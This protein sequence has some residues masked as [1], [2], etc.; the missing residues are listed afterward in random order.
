MTFI[1]LVYTR[2]KIF[3]LDEELQLLKGVINKA[4][5]DSS[6]TFAGFYFRGWTDNLFL[7]FQ[8]RFSSF[9]G[10]FRFGFV[11]FFVF[12]RRGWGR[13]GVVQCPGLENVYKAILAP[14][15][16]QNQRLL[17]QNF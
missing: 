6:N 9:Q 16:P 3:W 14:F 5:P 8:G 1:V 4:I 12:F 13:L 11:L 17:F 2:Q 15:I 7:L 10:R